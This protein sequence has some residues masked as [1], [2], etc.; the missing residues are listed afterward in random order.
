MEYEV[1][2]FE[3]ENEVRVGF[4]WDAGPEREPNVEETNRQ[5]D[6]A[7]RIA[8]ERNWQ[9]WDPD[10]ESGDLVVSPVRIV[11]GLPDLGWW[12]NRVWP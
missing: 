6:E 9:V 7:V 5:Y 11:A 1:M 4:D 2:I 12:A 10:D 8:Q 3:G